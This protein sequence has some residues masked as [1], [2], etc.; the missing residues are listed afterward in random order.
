MI[1]TF[2]TAVD[3]TLSELSIEAFFPAIAAEAA[4]NRAGATI[5]APIPLVTGKIRHDIMC[6][7]LRHVWSQLSLLSV[8]AA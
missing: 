7:G 1:T 8:P 2:G 5:V 4:V 6:F 3:V